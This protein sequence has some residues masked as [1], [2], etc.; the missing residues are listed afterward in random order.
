MR[1]QP[2]Y[3]IICGIS[4]TAIALILSIFWVNGS[5]LPAYVIASP[6][7]AIVGQQNV[8]E[9]ISADITFFVLGLAGGLIYGTIAW[10]LL[11]KIGVMSGFIIAGSAFIG[12]LLTWLFGTLIGPHDFDYRV[13]V[14]KV[15]EVVL[16]DINIHA[17]PALLSWPI[18]ALLIVFVSASIRTMRMKFAKDHQPDNLKDIPD[19][20]V[21][22][23]KNFYEQ[24]I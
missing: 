16:V 15:N 5:K 17:W 18:G 12:S 2:R 24:V 19:G 23:D 7:S 10:L 6:D 9:F 4:L 3:W 20:T 13:A 14:A 1:I 21:L 22:V 8:T 11:H